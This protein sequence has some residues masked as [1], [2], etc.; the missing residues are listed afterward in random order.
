[1]GATIRRLRLERSRADLADP[2][3]GRRRI[4]EIAKRW[5]FRHQA[6]YN[7]AFRRAYVMPPSDFRRQAL[8][9]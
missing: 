1:M 2:G 6:D 3:L 9:G 5:G 4:G 8:P 7:R